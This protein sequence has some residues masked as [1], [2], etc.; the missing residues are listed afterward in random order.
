MEV[1]FC[2]DGKYEQHF[3][4]A[5]TSLILNNLDHLTKVH[6]ITKKIT[7]N[8]QQKIDKLKTTA[9]IDFL[10]YQVED[11]EVKNLKVSQ[12]ISSAAYYRLLA[13]D[14]LPNHLNK[15]LYLDS[16]LIVNGSILELY[17]Y[18]ISN[19]VV[20]A[21]GK[22]VVTNKKRL[23]LNS[24]YYFNSGVMLINLETWR[25]LNIGKQCIELIRN[26][27][28]MIKL[29]DQDALNKVID[30][31]FLNLDQK[32]NSLVDLYDGNSQANDQSMIIHFIGSLKP[33][34]IWCISPAKELY[35]SYL[36][37]SPWSNSIPEIPKNS[38]QVLSAI[39]AIFK[40]LQNSTK[41]TK[42]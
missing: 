27:P 29:W 16:D 41:A 18:D 42:K 38:K 32:W 10:I 3:G 5:V 9:K 39:K 15:V 2:F 20:A 36:K 33:W 11:A 28:D 4:A 30:G 35:W 25:N 19:Y 31:D 12:H 40:Q 24:N 7:T 17:N 37:K 13:P 1:L 23:E 21:H 26:R 14:I 34:Q 22:K 6:I 8:F